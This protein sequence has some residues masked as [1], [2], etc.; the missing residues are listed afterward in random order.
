MSPVIIA[1]L[2]SVSVL[3]LL[4]VLDGIVLTAVDCKFTVASVLTDLRDVGTSPAEP[5]S[6][7][8]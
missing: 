8:R 3:T 1:F 2:T 5:V 4:K 6:D 7:Y